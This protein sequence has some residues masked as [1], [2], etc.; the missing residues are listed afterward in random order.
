[1]SDIQSGE[2][3]EFT[4]T[5]I[6]DMQ[7]QISNTTSTLGLLLTI[8]VCLCFGFMGIWAYFTR[9]RSTSE[10]FFGVLTIIFGLGSIGLTIAYSIWSSRTPISYL[11]S[12]RLI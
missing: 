1:M 4:K 12:Y 9:I 8:S 11:M 6:A 5:W 10:E 2:L 7:T 3:S